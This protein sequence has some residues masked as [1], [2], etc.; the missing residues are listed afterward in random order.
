MDSVTLDSIFNPKTIPI[1][2]TTSFYEARRKINSSTSQ[3]EKDSL[4]RVYY[5]LLFD[6]STLDRLMNDTIRI[7]NTE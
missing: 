1:I 5:L 2:T 6:S 3:K 4:T 7:D